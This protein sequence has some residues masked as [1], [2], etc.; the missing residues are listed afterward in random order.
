M[1]IEIIGIEDALIDENFENVEELVLNFK[2]AANQNFSTFCIPSQVPGSKNCYEFN[3]IPLNYNGSF[4]T[5]KIVG[6]YENGMMFEI[7]SHVDEAANKNNI[8]TNA[9]LIIKNDERP[10]FIITH[11]DRRYEQN[12]KLI[13][14]DDSS[15]LIP[16]NRKKVLEIFNSLGANA[17]EKNYVGERKNANFINKKSIDRMIK[18]NNYKIVFLVTG[19]LSKISKTNKKVGK[20]M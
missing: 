16:V 20:A 9:L 2:E 15:V 5:A 14:K 3:S 13:N 7:K 12:K 19:A 4:I 1:N 17:L 18:L 10:C 11:I 8:A 6:A